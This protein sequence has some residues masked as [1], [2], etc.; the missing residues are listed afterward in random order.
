MLLSEII[1]FFRRFQAAEESIVPT[2]A[3]FTADEQLQ[4]KITWMLKQPQREVML[5]DFLEKM[6]LAKQVV[7]SIQPRI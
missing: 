5:K 6:E 7:T 1:D 4:K 2:D 3:Q